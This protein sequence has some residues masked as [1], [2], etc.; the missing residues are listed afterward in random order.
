MYDVL[1]RTDSFSHLARG[2]RETIMRNANN[3]QVQ[4]Y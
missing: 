3:I 4:Q 2:Y 1:W